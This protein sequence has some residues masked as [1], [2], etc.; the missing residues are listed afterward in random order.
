M[1]GYCSSFLQKIPEFCEKGRQSIGI[2]GRKCT[3][4]A[5]IQG[6][7]APTCRALPEPFRLSAG[8]EPDLSSPIDLELGNSRPP[9]RVS[10]RGGRWWV[11]WRT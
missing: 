10:Q 6:E 1:S 4:Y 7:P 9:A 3:G 11:K 8:W 2:V 5:E